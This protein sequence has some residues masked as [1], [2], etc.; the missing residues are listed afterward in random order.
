MNFYTLL[1]CSYVPLEPGMVAVDAGAKVPGSETY[2]FDQVYLKHSNP[3]WQ[4]NSYC[5]KFSDGTSNSCNS[6]EICDRNNDNDDVQCNLR[7]K[8]FFAN[9]SVET[10]KVSENGCITMYK[11]C[12]EGNFVL[13]FQCI[14]NFMRNYLYKL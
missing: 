11:K 7:T 12:E 9:P 6:Y 5:D 14:K 13:Y 3:Y 10:T 4:C 2:Y 1:E 8:E